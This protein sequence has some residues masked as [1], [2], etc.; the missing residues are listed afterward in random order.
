RDS[1][2]L[3]E[4]KQK[5]KVL[6]IG[7]LGR[8]GTTLLERSLGQI[9][10]FCAVGEIRH[11]WDRS[12]AAN[13]LCGCGVPFRGCDFWTAVVDEAYGGFAALDASELVAMKYSVDRTRY[14]P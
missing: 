6:F 9:E 10:G 3:A 13:E 8:S 5:Q 2:R 7:A 4:Q 1:V 11:I 14:I 12:F